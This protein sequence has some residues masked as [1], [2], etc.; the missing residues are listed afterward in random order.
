MIWVVVMTTDKFIFHISWKIVLNVNMLGAILPCQNLPPLKVPHKQQ[1]IV[2]Q[3]TPLKAP[4]EGHV[5]KVLGVKIWPRQCKKPFARV[6]RLKSD[7]Q[8]QRS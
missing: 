3:L 2:G 6:H 4:A 1:A 8:A 5:V 7:I